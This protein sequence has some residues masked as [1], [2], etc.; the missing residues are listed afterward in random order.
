MSEILRKVVGVFEFKDKA[1][2]D[3]DKI[4]DSMD[5]GVESAFS[6][7]DGLRALGGAAVIAALHSLASASLDAAAA[8]ET[9]QV[10]LQN[11]AGNAY[12][13]LKSSMDAA[14]AASQGLS[15]EGDMSFAINQALKYG[16]S[17]DMLRGSMGSM[18]KLAA[19]TGD[20]L[21]SMFQGIAQDVATGSTRFIKQNA[22]LSKHMDAFRELGAGYDEA[23]KKKRE[24]FI[25]D[26]MQKEQLEIQ[27]QY[28]RTME[29]TNALLDVGASQWG[30][31]KERLGEIVAAGLKP[32][33]KIANRV[34]R[35]LGETE[36]G[37]IVLKLAVITLTP[38]IGVGLVLA[39]KAAAV[40]AWGL[41]LPLLP[42][43][44]IAAAVAAGIALITL[45]VEDLITFF[46]GGESFTA[47]I[48][49]IDPKTF[50]EG[51]R[52]IKDFIKSV[53]DF[54]KD[55]H[56]GI[57]DVLSSIAV[58]FDETFE[59]I[60]ITVQSVID[61]IKNI[62]KS[63]KNGFES[64]ANI[65]KEFF[66]EN[67]SLS[68]VIG[69]DKKEIKESIKQIKG[70][71][72][73]VQKIFG[74][75]HGKI[76]SIMD[77]IGMWFGRTF[78]SI[79]NRIQAVIDWFQRF[80]N[81]IGQ[82]INGVLELFNDIPGKIKEFVKGATEWLKNSKIGKVF[83]QLIPQVEAR[84]QGGPVV[85]GQQ[86]LVGESGP[87]LF[88]PD[89]SGTIVST[90]TLSQSAGAMTPSMQSIGSM[91]ENLNITV[92]TTGGT[93]PDTIADKV[94]ESVLDALNELSRNIFRAEMG[95]EVT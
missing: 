91:V 34:L 11:L 76:Q 25:V 38:L 30:N 50:Q 93:S 42:F 68:A 44:A 65:I 53:L 27:K 73:S 58:W 94:R 10:R 69:I 61:F 83:M 71:I 49:N 5:E 78:D 48:L 20:D 72:K 51:L 18:Q 54:F 79:T 31:I 23:T 37:L 16:A 92:N 40:A 74:K 6:L 57:I 46:K 24:L 32:L 17:V 81:R 4:N 88:V 35:F 26:I 43:I 63:V 89:Q 47:E 90:D 55:F 12:P 77:S 13:E 59:S 87:E 21:G 15:N 22:I 95:L 39:L 19:I 3:V 66:S 84:E 67:L 86:Y 41:I 45:A 9:Q 85:R 75:F 64:V 7:Q 2:K 70:F 60:K 14:I 56:D 52:I 29:T 36:E 8:L 80:H 28:N 62:P 33:L 82:A 1:S